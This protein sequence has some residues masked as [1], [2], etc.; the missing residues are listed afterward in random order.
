[1]RT[2]NHV[3]TYENGFLTKLNGKP[4]G[5]DKLEEQLNERLVENVL[6]K[7]PS[8]LDKIKRELFQ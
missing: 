8:I 6:R 4:I 2:P 5:N 7:S 1:M 3:V